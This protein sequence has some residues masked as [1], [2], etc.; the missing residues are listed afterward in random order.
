LSQLS[1][2][3]TGALLWGYDLQMNMQI[4]ERKPTLNSTRTYALVNPQET[5]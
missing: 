2:Y 1:I 5:Y 3:F 4:F